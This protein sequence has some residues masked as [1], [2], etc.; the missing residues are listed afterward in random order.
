[1]TVSPTARRNATLPT[2]AQWE[3]AARGEKHQKL[4]PWGNAM[5]V[6]SQPS[7]AIAHSSDP[8]GEGTAPRCAPTL[9]RIAAAA[10]SSHTW[11]WCPPAADQKR[12]AAV[13][14]EHLARAV[15][16]AR[17]PQHG[18]YSNKMALITS[19]CGNMRSLSI[20]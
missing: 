8:S 17:T 16:G 6:R 18:L 20:K 15:P 12:G 2:E 9:W 14:D 1:M 10:V 7:Y 4:Y 3:Y 5:Q 11:D 19:D 13:P